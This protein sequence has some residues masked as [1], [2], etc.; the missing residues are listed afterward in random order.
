MEQPIVVCG[1]GRVGWRVLEYLQAANLPVVIVDTNC[2]A[3]DP[4]LRGVRV[5]T[6]DCRRREI[7]EAAGVAQAR[8]VLILTGDDLLNISATL[9]VR[10]L[11]P[12][13]RVVLR[14]FNHNLLGRLGKAVRNVYALS[15]SMLTAPILAM[16]AMTG[17]GLGAFRL[18]HEADGRRQVAEAT[19]R[20]ASKLYGRTIAEALGDRPVLVLAHLPRQGTAK[21]LLEVDPQTRLVAG[22]RLVLCGEPRTLVPLLAESEGADAPHLLWAGRLRRWGRIAQRTLADLDRAVVL[23]TLVFIAVLVT[24]T[25]V[26]HFGNKKLTLIDALLRT[27][28]IMSVGGNLHEEDYPTAGTKLFVSV[29]R[30][31]GVALMGLFTAIVTNYLLRARLGGALEAARIPDGGHFIVCG[32]S[33]IGYRVVEELIAGG[34]QVVVIEMDPANRFVATVR[35]LRAA[36]IIGDATVGEVL[37][38]ARASEARAVVAAMHQDLVN[39]E[40]AL[41][42]REQKADQRVVLLMADP[43]L[44][45]MLR[46]AANVRL[47]VS[48]PTLAAPAFVAGLYGDR[49]LSVFLVRDRLLAVIDLVIQENDP[50]VNQAVKAVSADYRLLPAAVI[51]ANGAPPEQPLSASLAAG[52]RLVGIIAIPDLER[53][54]RRRPH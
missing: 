29:L 11:N 23:C 52:D 14:M 31:T 2:G 45:Q 46:D 25:L 34:E 48:V 44:A 37:R 27:L 49:V 15:T 20:P 39:L 19:V 35:R 32:L 12:D 21:H 47:A 17:Q 9:M 38:Q 4:R 42:V 40:I 8:G 6:G 7:L 18:E 13:V 3:D 26:L 36:M 22:D 43:Q 53:L 10:A 41:L 50:L 24:S 33:P 28:S 16:T 5:V 54:L 51:P 30:V 1:L